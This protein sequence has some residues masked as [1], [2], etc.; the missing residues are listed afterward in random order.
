MQVIFLLVCHQ[1]VN[2]VGKEEIQ[3]VIKKYDESEQ[4]SPTHKFTYHE[5]QKGFFSDTG[6]IFCA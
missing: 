4:K 2:H 1:N 6:R 5:I 3:K